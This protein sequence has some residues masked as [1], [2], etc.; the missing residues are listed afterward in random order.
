M[1]FFSV[2]DIVLK[3]KKKLIL[4]IVIPFLKGLLNIKIWF[5]RL[6][7]NSK[8]YFHHSDANQGLHM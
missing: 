2:M 8:L 6:N 7:Y 3:L 4:V 5:D 1:T